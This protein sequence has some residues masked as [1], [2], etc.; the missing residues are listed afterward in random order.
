MK[1]AQSA[2]QPSLTPGLGSAPQPPPDNPSSK[3]MAIGSPQPVPAGA[4]EPVIGRPAAPGKP[5]DKAVRQV[6]EVAAAVKRRRAGQTKAA[7]PK[8]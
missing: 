4:T 6:R 2:K 5:A 7:R 3:R 8:R 1:K